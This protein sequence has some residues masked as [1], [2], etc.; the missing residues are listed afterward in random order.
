MLGQAIA[1]GRICEWRQGE[2]WKAAYH[3]L[4]SLMFNVDWLA[5]AAK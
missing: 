5:A 4:R 1:A 2:E 3:V